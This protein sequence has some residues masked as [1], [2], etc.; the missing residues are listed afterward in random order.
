VSIH[1]IIDAGRFCDRFVLLSGGRVLAEGTSAELTA[2]ASRLHG[3]KAPAD[4]EEVFL[5][6]A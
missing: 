4:F 3:G 2:R 6:L 5:A 1:Q